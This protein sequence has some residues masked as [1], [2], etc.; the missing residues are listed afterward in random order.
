MTALHGGLTVLISRHHQMTTIYSTWFL[1]SS[2]SIIWPG[3]RF[4]VQV[5]LRKLAFFSNSQFSSFEV[6]IN[7]QIIQCFCYIL[8]KQTKPTHKSSTNRIINSIIIIYKKLKKQNTKTSTYMAFQP[9]KSV[10]FISEC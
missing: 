5:G 2:S 3:P 10:Y 9:S 8:F 4:K 1:Q 6:Y 7:Y